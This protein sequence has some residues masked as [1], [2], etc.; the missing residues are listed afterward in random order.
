MY[1]SALTPAK[2]MKANQLAIFDAAT[3]TLKSVEGLPS[4]DVISG[5][6]NTPFAEN[7]KAYIA[8]TTT[9]SYPAIYVIDSATAVATKGLTIEATQISGVGRLSPLGK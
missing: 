1:D 5:F 2:T 6:G 3:S 8:V 9:D 7:G 4:A